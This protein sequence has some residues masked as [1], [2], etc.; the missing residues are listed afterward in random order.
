LIRRII[1]RIIE[2]IKIIFFVIKIKNKKRKVTVSMGD[3][4]N[5]ILLHDIQCFY[6]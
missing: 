6:Q 5:K 3:C 4:Q 1:I 2:S